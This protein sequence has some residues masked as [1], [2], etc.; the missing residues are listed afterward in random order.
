[1]ALGDQLVK[2]LSKLIGSDPDVAREAHQS[3]SSAWFEWRLR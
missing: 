3:I 1:M 2:A